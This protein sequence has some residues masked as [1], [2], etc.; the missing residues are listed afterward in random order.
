[1]ELRRRPRN[2]RIRSEPG[3]ARR[4]WG[5][6]L[7]ATFVVV[8]F[9][10]LLG[11]SAARFSDPATLPIR[12]VF[13]EGEFRQ[14]KPPDLE[15]LVMRRVRGGF[16]TVRVAEVQHGL[17]R[18]PWVKAASVSREWPDGLR[19]TIY[20]ERAVARFGARGLL[21]PQGV[22]FSPPEA[23]YPSGLPLLDGP[24]GTETQVLMRYKRLAELLEPAGLTAR[25]L[26]QDAR[27]SWRFVVE[28]GPLVLVG[29]EDFEPR[30]KRFVA[31]YRHIAASGRG[32]VARVDLRH[33][34][35][36]AVS[37]K[38]MAAP[39]TRRPAGGKTGEKV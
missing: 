14:L 35:G 20:E 38:P 15:D 3:R 27:G 39:A 18:D 34:N 33:T 8:D 13:I 21:N 6:W 11:L 5:L 25:S 24:E 17:S 31:H 37:F 32:E 30:V 26:A 36:I 7:V 28:D 16:F 29:R 22:L 19:V 12:K 1:M 9:C 10:L 4:P 2:R 23:S